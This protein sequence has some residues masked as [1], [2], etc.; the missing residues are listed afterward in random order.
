M[1][2]AGFGGNFESERYFR[3]IITAIIAYEKISTHQI[4]PETPVS[5]SA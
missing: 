3:E 4:F 1:I 5:L 2:D